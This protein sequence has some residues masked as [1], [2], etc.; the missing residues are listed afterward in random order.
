[1]TSADSKAGISDFP[2]PRIAALVCFG[3]AYVY[4]CLFFRGAPWRP[5]VDLS[6]VVAVVAWPLAFWHRD[7]LSQPRLPHPW[8][9]Y[10]LYMAALTPFV[11]NWRWALTG[12]NLLWPLEGLKVAANGP[13]RSLLSVYGVDNFGYLQTNLHNVFMYAIS[14]TLFWHR[15]GKLGVALL[16]MAAVYTV[17]SR[18]VR[19][20]FG[21]LV[22]GCT[23][24]CSVWI[25]YTYASVPFLDGIASGFAL[26]AI[27]L[28]IERDPASIRAW[29]ALG[30]LSG[31]M[32]FLTPNGWL[33]AACVWLWLAGLTLLRQWNIRFLALAAITAVIVG[34]PMLLQWAAGKGLMFTLV[35]KPAWTVE[36]VLSF[37]QQAAFMPFDSKVD[38]SGAFGPQLPWGFRW[39]F[40]LGVFLTPW[41]P[42]R[43]PGA[44]FVF[45]L[46]AAHIVLLAFTQGPYGAVSVKRALVLI[47]MATYFV[48][49]PFHRW[50]VRP[51]AALAVIA[52]WSTFGIHDVVTELKPGRTGYTFF[53]G[54]I[55]AHQLFAPAM[56]CVYMIGDTRTAELLPGSALDRLYGLS[57]RI[58]LVSNPDDPVCAQVLC[59]CSQE[60]CRHL[61]LASRG[62]TEE[63]M[64]N[65]VE[66]R[67]GRKPSV[68][69]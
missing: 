66:L 64:L 59:Y 18:L 61:D 63:A 69:N 37:L 45:M 24:T 13:D 28:W 58:R 4:L 53:D 14:P 40:L 2:S 52:V 19:P 31:F 27:G 43:F 65:T 57:P 26:L 25:V 7:T 46:L 38:N 42:R 39:L 33:M 30:W 62:Y 22:A 36:K 3:V 68:A 23:A 56:I 9:F 60:R 21:L 5:L 34:T 17:F 51:A 50:F 12:D 47:P 54:V 15:I 20:A 35:A 11:A 67:C 44:R 29:L 48:F 10:G 1:V 32:L 49:L 41:A 6:W 8:W 55:E 16:A